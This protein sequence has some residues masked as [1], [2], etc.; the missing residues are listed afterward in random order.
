M[1]RIHVHLGKSKLA[2]K[3]AQGNI[4]KEA[5]LVYAVRGLDRSLLD[6]CYIVG[7]NSKNGIPAKSEILYVTHLS[8]VDCSVWHLSRK[9]MYQRKRKDVVIGHSGKL[10]QIPKIV[11][12]DSIR[13]STNTRPKDPSNADKSFVY[14]DARHKAI[15][16]KPCPDNPTR[17]DYTPA[18]AFARFS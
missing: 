9:K 14:A 6:P 11:P 16:R 10:A 5:E 17:I 1:I 7:D 12:V 18:G 15:D 3:D 2:E 4:T 8:L 13:I